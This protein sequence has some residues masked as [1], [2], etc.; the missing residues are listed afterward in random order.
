MPVSFELKPLKNDGKRFYIIKNLHKS[1]LSSKPFLSELLN[2]GE[3]IYNFNEGKIIVQLVT[4]ME[5]NRRKRISSGFNGISWV[6]TS[7]LNQGA[8][9]YK[10]KS[11]NNLK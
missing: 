3:I 2:T 9:L 7:I 4:P 1:F 5:A 11:E 8:I 6:I 10:K